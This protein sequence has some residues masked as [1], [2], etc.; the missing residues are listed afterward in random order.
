MTP[1]MEKKIFLYGFFFSSKIQIHRR[2]KNFIHSQ[3]LLESRYN[4]Y[5]NKIKNSLIHTQGTLQKRLASY[6]I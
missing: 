5:N 3:L 4:I 6:I 1:S 2:G